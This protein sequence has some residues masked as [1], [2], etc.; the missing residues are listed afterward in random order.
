MQCVNHAR[1][2]EHTNV[3]MAELLLKISISPLLS[4]TRTASDKQCQYNAARRSSHVR[5]ADP[6]RIPDRSSSRMYLYRRNQ[7]PASSCH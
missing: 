2:N 6:A 4:H 3:A 5:G 7:I 1:M